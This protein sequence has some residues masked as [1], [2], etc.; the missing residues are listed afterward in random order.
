M[1]APSSTA[2]RPPHRVIGAAAVPET[3]AVKLPW[4]TP[5]ARTMSSPGRA[6]ASAVASAL[7]VATCTAPAL[8]QAG[9]LAATGSPDGDGDALP[10][11]DGLAGAPAAFGWLDGAA[12]HAARE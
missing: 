9:G 1:S 2:L 6:P 4:Y 12:E 11:D 7:A 10:G 5:G 8:V 3:P